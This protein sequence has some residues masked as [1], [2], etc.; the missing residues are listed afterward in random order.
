M[1]NPIFA[2][3]AR[4]GS[5]RCGERMTQIEAAFLREGGFRYKPGPAG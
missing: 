1:R 5:A 2:A 3:A 4:P